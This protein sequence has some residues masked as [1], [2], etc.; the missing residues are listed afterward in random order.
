MRAEKENVKNFSKKKIQGMTTQAASI[1]LR[2]PPANPSRLIHQTTPHHL[3]EG[4]SESS[5]KGL[6]INHYLHILPYETSCCL[7]G[8]CCTG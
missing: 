4:G 7:D 5:A 1:L 3:C 6:I 8:Y 2:L